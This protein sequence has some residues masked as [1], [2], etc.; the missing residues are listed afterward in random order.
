MEQMATVLTVTLISILLPA[1]RSGSPHI[2][3]HQ[4]WEIVNPV[5]QAVLA[6]VS[7]SQWPR[8][9][10]F[11]Q[12]TI[13]LCVLG[14]PYQSSMHYCAPNVPGLPIKDYWTQYTQYPLYGCPGFGQPD[15]CGGHSY[16]FCATW[17]CV[18]FGTAHWITNKD[19]I[20]IA[21]NPSR[22]QTCSFNPPNCNPLIIKFTNKGKTDPRWTEG[23]TW[24]LRLYKRGPDDVFLFTLRLRVTPITNSMGPNFVLTDQHRPSYQFPQPPRPLSPTQFPSFTLPPTPIPKIP[25]GT[26]DRLLKLIESSYLVLNAT[27]PNLTISCWLCLHSQPPYYEGIAFTDH[28]YNTSAPSPRCARFPHHFT[29]A[30]VS[31]KGLCIGHPPS[32]HSHLCNVTLPISHSPHYLEAPNNTFWACNTGLTPCISLQVF[33]TSSEFCVLIQLWPRI[34]YHTDTALEKILS[35]SPRVKREPLSTIA[36]I[37]GIGGLAAGIG[38]GTT[39]YLQTQHLTT[40][41]ADMTTDI[42]ILE[43]SVSAL[44]KSLSS[45][46]EVVL[47]NRRGLDLLF[48]KEGGLCVAIKEECCF[49]ADHTGMV[50]KSMAKLRER[51]AL[52]K[53]KAEAQEGWYNNLLRKTPWLS[54]LIPTIIAPVI[55]ILLILTFGPW[56]FQRLTGFI[57]SNIDSALTKFPTVQYHRI[58]ITDTDRP[59]IPTDRLQFTSRAVTQ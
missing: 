59:H 52:R 27:A 18:T 36:I 51:L 31:G 29:L 46:S 4:V 33:N 53:K 41:H 42:E 21:R 19:L 30:E 24:G 57:K 1:T 22:P 10:W 44:A 7:S 50:R 20:T 55:I 54:T 13:D 9:T 43:K 3:V 5:N 2:P 47:Q 48:L 8:L 49:Y 58:E 12:L 32:S 17:G 26:T 40:L 56:A 25:P 34:T 38:T 11:P 37:L 6:S 15:H 14:I 16:G 45:L 28:P 39:A 35:P 23:L